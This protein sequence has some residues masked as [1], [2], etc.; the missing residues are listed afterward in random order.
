MGLVLALLNFSSM[1]GLMLN[2]CP[3]G[4]GA[5]S[6]MFVSAV[7]AMEELSLVGVDIG[8]ANR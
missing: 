5:T 7:L 2:L 3:A 8:V 6:A 1:I 4:R